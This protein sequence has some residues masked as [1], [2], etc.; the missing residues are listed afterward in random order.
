MSTNIFTWRQTVY[1]QA[2][3]EFIDYFIFFNNEKRLHIVRIFDWD[4]GHE[5]NEL[6]SIVQT[7]DSCIQFH[8]NIVVFDYYMMCHS[9]EVCVCVWKKGTQ[10]SQTIEE[11]EYDNNSNAKKA[12]KKN[13]PK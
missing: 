2:T 1:S 5:K 4:L 11:R 12:T 8:P 13:G 6:N 7:F 10:N 3:Y 9:I